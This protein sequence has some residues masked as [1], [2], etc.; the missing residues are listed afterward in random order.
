MHELSLRMGKNQ[1]YISQILKRDHVPSINKMAMIAK[2][3]DLSVADLLEGPGADL[4]TAMLAR[5]L[6]TLTP[7]QRDAV[8]RMIDSLRQSSDELQD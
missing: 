6:N 8:M 5:K 4:D 7:A 3:L 2:E 1:H